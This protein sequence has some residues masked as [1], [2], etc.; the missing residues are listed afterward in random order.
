MDSK[1]TLTWEQAKQIAEQVIF[2]HFG[3]HLRDAEIF[4]L[5]GAWNGLT[6][7]KIAEL[8]NFTVNY[9]RGDV[10]SKL[11]Q[12]LSV[13]L[14]EEIT[15]TNFRWAFQRKASD[16]TSSVSPW[17]AI[18]PFPEGPE[19][20]ESPLYLERVGVESL[21][22]ETIIKPGSLISIKAPK[23]MGKTSL[24]IRIIAQA[25][26][27][28]YQTASLNLRTVARGII[29]NLDKF[30]RW[31][32]LMVGNQ[33]KLENRLRDYWDTETL[34]S[35]DN[36]SAYF[37][38]YL[39]KQIDGPLLLG[40][41]DVDKIFPYTEVADD[42]L[43]MLRS[44]H[45]K[46]KASQQW[47]QLRLVMAHSTECYVTLDVNQS[48]FNAGTPL[49]LR[50]FDQKQVQDLTLLHALDWHQSQIEALMTMVGGHPYLVRVALYEVTAQNITLE[51]LLLEASSES[52][53]YIN[54]LRQHREMLQQ[55]CELTEA[56]KKVVLSAMPVELDSR[57][58]YKLH[59]M[60]LVKKTNNQVM[61]RC[62]LY[63]EYFLR[64]LS[65]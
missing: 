9:L 5:E 62:N 8:H 4:V 57:Q 30:L 29:T 21:C 15:K 10:G 47:R 49:Q 41:D 58:I 12:K 7:E 56:L 43:G 22:Y 52:G 2:K 60:G 42:F 26:S 38:Q 27:H 65:V 28:N 18:L 25:Q 13:A 23:L 1:S 48:P 24:M 6:Y 53:I 20:L 34:G 37:E 45:D 11:W 64:I 54:H 16:V 40:L 32:C 63:R 17:V 36:C 46:G 51:R 19:A 31:F 39:L 50:E 3:E 14:Q 33:L 55:S 44:W 35:N 61:P 59:S